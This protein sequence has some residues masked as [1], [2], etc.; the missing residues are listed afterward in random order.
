[1]KVLTTIDL[2][3]LPSLETPPAGH[4]GFGAKSDG[5]YQKVGTVEKKLSVEGHVH[6]AVTTSVAGFMSAADKVKLN[7]I[8]TGANN[9]SHPTGAG[10]NH[11]PTGGAAGQYLKWSSSGVAVWAADN[12]TTYG[13]ATTLANGLMSAADKV[14]LDGV[15]TGANNYSLPTASATVLGGVKIGSNISISSGVI[16]VAAPYTHPSSHPATIITQTSSYRFV[17]DTEKSTWNAKSNLALG[18]TSTTAYRGDLGAIAYN[19]SQSAHAYLPLAGGTMADTN[20]V[21]NLNADLLDGKHYSDVLQAIE[22]AKSTNH[23]YR[24]SYNLWIYGDHDKYYPFVLVGG[25]QNVKRDILIKRSYSETHPAEWNSA[26][27]GGGLTLKL[28]AN[29]GGWGGANYGWE[30]HELEEMYNPTFGG[31]YHTTSY[32]SF[33]IMLRGGGTGGAIYHI[34]SDQPIENTHGLHLNGDGKTSSNFPQ[35][36]YNKEVLQ[37]IATTSTWAMPTPLTTPNTEDIRKRKF[38][39]LVQDIDTLV[40]KTT[41]ISSLNI[42]GN[43]A[44]ATKLSNIVTSFTGTYPVTFNVN[45]TIYSHTGITYTGSTGALTATNFIG[46]LTGNASTAT[47]LGT[48]T[49]GSTQLPF[50]LNAGTATAITQANLRIGL[51]GTTAIGSTQLPIYLAA[52]GVPTAITQANLR[53]GLFGATAIGSATKPVYIAANGVPTASTSFGGVTGIGTASPLMDGTVAV[54]TSSLA[55][56]QDHRHP[57][58]TSRAAVAQTMY[59]GTTAVTI[60]RASATLNLTGIG[61]LAMAGALSGATTIAASTSVTTPKVIFAAAGW[62]VEQSG[63]EIQ[64]KYN[65]VIKQRLLSDGGIVGIGEVTAFGST[66]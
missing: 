43:A 40:G 8:A 44:T 26:T 48:A 19:H 59:I 63:T 33:S 61:T 60:N 31:C 24:Y 3:A 50:Y 29:F 23:G 56:R 14:K 57:V 51:F 25:D 32:M 28:K 21:T 52:N 58:D 47:K 64:F 66:T 65:G 15:A 6:S 5:L 22:V 9:Y 12:N 41:G 37:Y 62:S 1:M 11:I 53:I 18:T 16:S 54:G 13:V 39:K 49:V 38:I 42:T 27:H 4:V 45:G 2:L 36:F 10:S 30:I 55:A 20:L 46:N 17:T 34:Y 7:G 35:V